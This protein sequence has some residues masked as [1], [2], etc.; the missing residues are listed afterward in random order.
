M[1]GIRTKD[2]NNHADNETETLSMQKMHFITFDI[3]AYPIHTLLNPTDLRME[4]L[5][6]PKWGTITLHCV[7]TRAATGTV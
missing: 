7:S 6:A 4:R 1:T 3:G 2:P 5:E